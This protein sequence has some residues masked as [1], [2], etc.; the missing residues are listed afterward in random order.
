MI[1]IIVAV[2]NILSLLSMI[3]IIVVIMIILLLFYNRSYSREVCYI[4]VIRPSIYVH[5][6][7]T[8]L[9]EGRQERK[10]NKGARGS[11]G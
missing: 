10:R 2:V 11:K 3:V 8:L 9:S 6:L 4:Q 1:I 7:F 5:L